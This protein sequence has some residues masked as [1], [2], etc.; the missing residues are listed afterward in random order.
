MLEEA[1]SFLKKEGFFPKEVVPLRGDGSARRF[2]RVR[3]K[4]DSYILI[5]PQEGAFGLKEARS[6]VTLGGFL[7]R[8]GVPVPRM[9]AFEEDKGFVLVEDLGE[10]RLYDLAPEYL[11]SFYPEVLN[12]WATFPGLAACFPKE[13]ALEGLFYDEALMWEK[14]ALYF[15]RSFLGDFCGL[16]TQV[17]EEVEGLLKALWARLKGFSQAEAFLHRDFQAKNL[18]LKDGRVYVI[19]FQAARLGPAAYDLASLLLDPYVALSRK[20]RE[21][22]FKQAQ[23]LFPVSEE[24][25]WALALF[26]NF[27]ILGAFAKLTLAGKE[28]FRAYIPQAL[29]TLQEIL[30]LF[31]PEGPKLWRLLVAN[32][33]F[34]V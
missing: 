2:F 34:P 17:L 13:A 24:A 30:D 8:A 12:I 32:A 26:R 23:G 21:R 10:V 27:Q 25:F 31:P 5:L 1:C 4:K 14:E 16:K 7:F 29:V 3:T 9:M 15:K 19:D 6:Y 11:L 22:L 18:M 20:V 28:W 33:G